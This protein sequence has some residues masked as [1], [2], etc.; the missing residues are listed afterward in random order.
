MTD[1]L[2]PDAPR[3]ANAD[4]PKYIV[5]LDARYQSAWRELNTRITQRQNAL[6]LFLIISLAVLGFVFGDKTTN[7]DIEVK[8]FASLILPSMGIVLGFLNSKHEETIALLRH[9]LRQCER[10]DTRY[11]S[12]KLYYNAD[13]EYSSPADRYRRNH[14][15]AFFWSIIGVATVGIILSFSQLIHQQDVTDWR[16]LSVGALVYAVFYIG[17]TLAAL[18]IVRSRPEY[19]RP[20]GSP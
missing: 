3:P 1:A 11:G 10:A 19:D 8:M 12:V 5:S 17:A 7:M 6:Y 14:A 2:R 15:R 13:S 16:I 9:Y 18:V 4:D 20:L